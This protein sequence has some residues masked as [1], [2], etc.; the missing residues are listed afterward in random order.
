V[1]VAVAVTVAVPDKEQ[2]FLP[3]KVL[4]ILPIFLFSLSP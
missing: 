1:A 4:L 2:T 3:S